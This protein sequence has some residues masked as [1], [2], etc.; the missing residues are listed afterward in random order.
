MPTSEHLSL[1]A[2]ALP[3]SIHIHRTH[4]RQHKTSTQKREGA[5]CKQRPL[6]NHKACNQSER[7][8]DCKCLCSWIRR[9]APKHLLQQEAAASLGF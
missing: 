9:P 6:G 4:T 8:H 7:T 5:F 3:S 2:S 1:C